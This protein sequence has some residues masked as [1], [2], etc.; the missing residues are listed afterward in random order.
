MNFGH[1]LAITEFLE[2]AASMMKLTISSLQ[3]DVMP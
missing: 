2:T 1:H 3:I